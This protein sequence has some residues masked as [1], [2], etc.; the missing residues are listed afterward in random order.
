MDF[1]PIPVMTI[2]QNMALQ[3]QPANWNSRLLVYANAFSSNYVAVYFP[4]RFWLISQVLHFYNS[5]HEWKLDAECHTIFRSKEFYTHFSAVFF[6]LWQETVTIQHIQVTNR[7][8][9]MVLMLLMFLQQLHGLD[10]DNIC[11]YTNKQHV[12][13]SLHIRVLIL[14]K[15]YFLNEM[16]L[17]SIKYYSLTLPS[18]N[19]KWWFT[20]VF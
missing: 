14:A 15:G 2:E 19:G 11:L 20:G 5:F 10:I 7:Y 12:A 8:L 9:Q 13:S 4:E 17:F 16:G 6:I 1:L 18:R 3:N